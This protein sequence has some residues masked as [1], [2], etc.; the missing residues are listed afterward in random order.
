MSDHGGLGANAVFLS[1][2]VAISLSFYS[3]ITQKVINQDT[4]KNILVGP[5]M[6]V[7]CFSPNTWEVE[8]GGSL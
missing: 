7:Y 2:V 6:V 1:N 5:G 4:L 3:N 8:A